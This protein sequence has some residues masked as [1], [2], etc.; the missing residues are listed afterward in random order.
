MTT[1]PASLATAGER[2]TFG[3]PDT[4]RVTGLSRASIYDAIKNKQLRAI[5]FG[6]R[7]LIRRADLDQFLASL[8]ELSTRAS[9]A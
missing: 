9:A 2:V 7:T 5:K 1:Q 6:R 8:P 3:I 4:C